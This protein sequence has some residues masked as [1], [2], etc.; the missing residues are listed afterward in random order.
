MSGVLGALALLALVIAASLTD[1]WRVLPLALGIWLTPVLLILLVSEWLLRRRRRVAANAPATVAFTGWETAEPTTRLPALGPCRDWLRVPASMP[2]A[3]VHDLFLVDLSIRHTERGFPRN[4]VCGAASWRLRRGDMLILRYVPPVALDDA[5]IPPVWRCDL[6]DE[7]NSTRRWM[8]VSS[9]RELVVPIERSGIWSVGAEQGDLSQ[10]G[11][12]TL[13]VWLR[14]CF[15][16]DEVPESGA[17]TAVERVPAG[18]RLLF[19]PQHD[20]WS[21]A[22]A[23]DQRLCAPQDGAPLPRFGYCFEVAAGEVLA[24]ELVWPLIEPLDG[25][26]VPQGLLLLRMAGRPTWFFRAFASARILVTVPSTGRCELLLEL[27]MPSS[28][29]PNWP[30]LRLWSARWHAPASASDSALEMREAGAARLA[31]NHDLIDGKEP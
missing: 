11:S 23:P 25:G 28:P 12:G 24:L 16:G 17:S 20:G 19:D 1:G 22:P 10:D 4:G 18:A 27:D 21:G 2:G 3:G 8:T 6:L 15:P 14:T 26:R 9:D 31:R 5:A 30:Q 7:R 29:A 13:G